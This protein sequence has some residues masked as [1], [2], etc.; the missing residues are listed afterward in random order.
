MKNKTAGGSIRLTI[1][2]AAKLLNITPSTLRNWEKYGLFQAK[3]SENGYRFYTFEDIEFLKRIRKYMIDDNGRTRALRK[4]DAIK[5]PGRTDAYLQEMHRDAYGVDTDIS[6][7]SGRRWKETRTA[8]KFTL[9]DVSRLTGISASYLSKIEN[10]K[11]VPSLETLSSLATFYGES[12]VRF[13]LEGSSSEYSLVRKK[14][15]V[16][17]NLGYSNLKTYRVSNLRGC[18]MYPVIHALAPAATSGASHSHAGEELVYILEGK[19][20]VQLN[21]SDIYTLLPGDTM[22]FK[23]ITPHRYANNSNKRTVVLWVHTA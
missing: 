3:R 6:Q 23:A 21:E 1:S 2:E 22:T 10:D 5:E 20:T 16:C 14:E 18:Q 17:M 13:T 7:Y 12:L 9:E 4:I 15:A 11:V 8:K 19:L